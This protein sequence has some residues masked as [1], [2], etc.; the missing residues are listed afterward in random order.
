MDLK[1]RIDELPLND[2]FQG[3]IK[4]AIDRAEEAIREFNE[5]EGKL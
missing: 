2:L 4:E 5:G 1:R 3:E